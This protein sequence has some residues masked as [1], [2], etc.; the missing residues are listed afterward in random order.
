MPEKVQTPALIGRLLVLD[1]AP[2]FSREFATVPEPRMEH[3]GDWS[4]RREEAWIMDHPEADEKALRLG[5][6]VFAL[7]ATTATTIAESFPPRER[8]RHR[9]RDWR[10][11]ASNCG[12]L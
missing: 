2:F 7:V 9:C 12:V 5:L 4:P 11:K 1:A 10:E 8:H 3:A 6:N